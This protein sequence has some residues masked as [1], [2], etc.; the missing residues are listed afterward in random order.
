MYLEINLTKEVNNLYLEK[1]TTLK[2]EI[3]EDTNKYSCIGRIT[4]IKMSREY[5][6]VWPL[7]KTIWNFLRKLKMELPFDPAIPLLDYILSP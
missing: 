7:W 3:K 1:Y 5:R 2:E 6:L 4:I